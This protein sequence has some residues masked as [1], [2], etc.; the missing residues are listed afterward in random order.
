MQICGAEAHVL[1][2]VLVAL[3]NGWTGSSQR[4]F[5][6]KTVLSLR[7]KDA[8]GGRA[9]WPSCLPE[10]RNRQ[11]LPGCSRQSEGGSYHRLTQ[12]RGRERELSSA[13]QC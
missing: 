12:A 11:T 8:G 10:V 7:E 1:A 3:D 2:P 9:G 5:P 4:S 6:T 13:G